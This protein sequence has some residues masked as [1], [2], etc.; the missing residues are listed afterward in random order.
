MPAFDFAATV[1]PFFMVCGSLQDL[2]EI[3]ASKDFQ[4]QQP[5]LQ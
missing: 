3:G 4:G 2:R 1:T 5:T